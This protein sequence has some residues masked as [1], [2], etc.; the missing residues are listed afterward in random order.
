MCMG[1]GSILRGKGSVLGTVPRRWTYIETKDV[2]VKLC[3]PTAPHV[4]PHVCGECA[5]HAHVCCRPR[6]TNVS[7]LRCEQLQG[8]RNSN[9]GGAHVGGL[10]WDS[11][12]QEWCAV[13]EKIPVHESG[14]ECS[15]GGGVQD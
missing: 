8:Q 12:R 13:L 1:H 9:R 14:L 10:R 11:G 7:D 5:G 3:R 4:P 6:L 2:L 15:G